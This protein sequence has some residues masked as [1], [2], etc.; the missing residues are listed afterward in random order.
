MLMMIN[1]ELWQKIQIEINVTTLEKGVFSIIFNMQVPLGQHFEGLRL[2]TS[3]ANLFETLVNAFY[4]SDRPQHQ[5]HYPGL[6]DKC[7]GSFKV[8][9]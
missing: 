8:F 4:E 7:I 2:S 6:F 1:T 5:D 3:A 9:Q